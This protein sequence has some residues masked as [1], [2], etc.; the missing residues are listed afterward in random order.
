MVI[1]ALAGYMPVSAYPPGSERAE[2]DSR[3]RS[4]ALVD[5]GCAKVYRKAAVNLE[6]GEF[7]QPSG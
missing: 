7:T 4:K 5:D 6:G 2:S 1:I 3:A